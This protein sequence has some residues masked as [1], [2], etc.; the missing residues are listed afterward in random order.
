MKRFIIFLAAAL[1]AA[2]SAPAPQ[3]DNLVRL[4]RAHMEQETSAPRQN[5]KNKGKVQHLTARRVPQDNLREIQRR[6]PQPHHTPDPRQGPEK[7][8]FPHRLHNPKT[9]RNFA[10]KSNRQKMR[11][12]NLCNLL[13]FRE[14]P[15]PSRL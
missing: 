5:R 8:N 11:K 10:V 4:H 1:L 3:R 9:F 7:I 14:L 13:I 12:T 15:P 6:Q 2:G